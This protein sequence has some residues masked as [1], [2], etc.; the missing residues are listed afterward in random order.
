MDDDPRLDPTGRL[1]GDFVRQ[2][3]AHV[4]VPDLT[5][6]PQIGLRRS[7]RM[8]K[9]GRVLVVASCALVVAGAIA[10]TVAYGPRSTR[11][12]TQSVPATQPPPVSTSTSS[13][14]GGTE[15]ITYEP[16]TATGIDPSLHVT[17]RFT[18]NC[19]RYSRGAAARSYFRCFASGGGIYDPC[20]AGPQSTRAPL[21]CPTTPTS[22]SVVT[23]TVSTV[24]S[25]GPPSPSSIPWAMQLSDGQVCLFVSAAWSGLG[26]YQCGAA[27][28]G[29]SVA[30]CHPPD[31]TPSST[32][33]CQDQFTQ[34]SPFA[35]TDVAKLWF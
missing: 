14:A 9:R 22:S 18:G 25:D 35:P 4:V 11:V 32:A 13:V 15:R 33:A 20:F 3:S 24:S 2:V 10:V 19:I 26:P 27:P 8:H 23:F 6:G 7:G 29:P 17:S 1:L 28:I 16:F 31:A 5:E 30:D 12:G 21:V 34:T